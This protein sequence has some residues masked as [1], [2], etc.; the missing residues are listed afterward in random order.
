MKKIV[1]V[2]AIATMLVASV[3][4]QGLHRNGMMKDD[5][6]RMGKGEMRGEGFGMRHEG[7]KGQGM[8]HN[9]CG[10]GMHGDG[11]MMAIYKLDLTDAQE[12]DITLIKENHR[13]EA[14]LKKAE[15]ENLEIDMHNYMKNA[16]FNKAL[17]VSE[18]INN[19]KGKMH[20]SRIKMIQSIYNKLTDDQKNEVKETIKTFPNGRMHKMNMGGC[21]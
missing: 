16:D 3:F 5:D 17:K 6:C 20:E 7:M 1:L 14:N 4:A 19:A 13:K 10:K 15:I 11:M 21:K 12:D 8:K 18:Q 2:L 9:A